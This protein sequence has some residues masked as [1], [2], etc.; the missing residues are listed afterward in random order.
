MEAA[1]EGRFLDRVVIT[2]RAG[3]GGDGIVAFRRE[4][5]VPKGGPSGGSGGKGGSVWFLVDPRLTTLADFTNGAFFRASNGTPGG[6][7]NMTGACGED[8]ILRIPPG[9]EIHDQ[10]TGELLADMTEPGDRFRIARGGEPGRGNASFATPTRRTPRI[11]TRGKP[12]EEL[13]LRLDLKLMA[14]AGLVGF[15]NAGK[16]TLLS[17]ISAAR[18]RTADY[19]FTTLSP[20]LG[21]VSLGTGR[22]FTVADLPGLLEGASRGVGLGHRFL[23]HAQRNRILV[24]VLSPDLA[25]TPVEQLEILRRELTEYAGD[26]TGIRAM[27]VLSK[28]DTIPPEVEQ[29]L[30]Q[31]LPPGTMPISSV[32]GKGVREFI[33]RLGKLILE[34]KGSNQEPGPSSPSPSREH[35]G[36]NS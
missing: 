10:S 15:P 4:A 23:R 6:R 11:C 7:N 25:V 14:D 30:L 2:V 18:P 34:L 28:C 31:D 13:K 32:T 5:Y 35:P 36:R 1:L 22:S 9:T 12:G 24:F 29:E 20:S 17:R 26:L 33:H 3:R 27:A 16:S 21:V 19:P 8:L